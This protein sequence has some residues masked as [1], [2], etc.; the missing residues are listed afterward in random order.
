MKF[1]ELRSVLLCDD[2]GDALTLANH[3]YAWSYREHLREKMLADFAGEDL[4]FD[5]IGSGMD[6]YCIM[7]GLQVTWAEDEPTQPRY[8]I[9]GCMTQYG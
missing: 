5:W 8:E 9:T 3:F 7:F 2:T 4:C 1:G 6:G